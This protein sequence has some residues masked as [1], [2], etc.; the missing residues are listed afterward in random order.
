M[1]D[2]T[3]KLKK[4][5]KSK[6]KTFKGSGH[7]LG[8]APQVCTCFAFACRIGATTPKIKDIPVQATSSSN[9]TAPK[10]YQA[11]LPL[12]SARPRVADKPSQPVNSRPALGLRDVPPTQ[13]SNVPPASVVTTGAYIAP[14]SL[15]AATLQW[16]PIQLEATA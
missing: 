6:P 13:Q 5:F 14:G 9:I 2:V 16:Y 15:Q 3:S 8:A 7:K 1:D 11:P 12:P 4:L 10:S